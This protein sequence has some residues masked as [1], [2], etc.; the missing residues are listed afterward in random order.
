MRAGGIEKT[1]EV[2]DMSQ[3]WIR[4]RLNNAGF[5]LTSPRRIILDVLQNRGGHLSAE[6]IYVEA[7]KSKS[8]IGLTT[9]YR[10][11]DLFTKTGIAQRFD[12][13]DGKARYELASL[14]GKMTHHHHL[15]CIKCNSIIDYTDFI[16]EEI[17]LM[18]RT[19]RELSEK[20]NFK[21]INHTIHL[22]GLC[23]KCLKEK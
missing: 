16:D 11:M 5:R 7:L 6:D 20:Y 8:S 19:E 18:D 10:T 1:I 3:E 15:V 22:Y 21:I 12:F 4:G 23:E 14:P 17:E 2:N 13:G 9:V